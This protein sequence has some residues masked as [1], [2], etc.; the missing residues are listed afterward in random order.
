V[1]QVAEPGAFERAHI[2]GAVLVTPAELVD[3][4]PPATGR[5][6]DLERLTALIA[7]IGYRPGRPVVVCDD[8]GGG[9]AGRFAWTLDV[10]GDRDWSYLNGGIH[11]WIA[12]GREFETGPGA[13]PARS[14]FRPV[15]DLA[16]VAEAEDVLAAINAPDALVW[17]VRSAAEYRGERR[18]A[19]R[20]GHIPGAVNLDWLDLRDPADAM[21]LV[22]DLGPLLARHGITP[23]H[24]VITHCQTHHRSGLSYMVGR[25]LGFPRIRAYHGSWSEWGNR[26]DLPIET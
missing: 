14:S 25:I 2:P 10:I 11:A 3:G 16:P 18:A 26:E 6:P 12:A 22:P 13:T 20:A 1:V 24:D 15:L 21:R 7:R 19:A 23:A 9:W 8:E 4:R 17:D 5:L